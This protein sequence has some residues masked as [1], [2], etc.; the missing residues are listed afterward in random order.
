MRLDR[1]WIEQHIPHQGRMC[2]LDE[3]LEWTATSVRTSSTSHREQDNPLQSHGHLA[4]VCGIEYAAQTMAVHGALLGA[5]SDRSSGAGYLIS[6]R[7][8]CMHVETLSEIMSDLIVTATRT[9]GDSRMV[10]YEFAVYGG[11][12]VVLNGRASVVF[13]SNAIVS[14]RRTLRAP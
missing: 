10:V 11:G 14:P 13:E 8:V 7:N 5:L 3:V 4:T 2:L 6:V 12:Q 1:H 9:G